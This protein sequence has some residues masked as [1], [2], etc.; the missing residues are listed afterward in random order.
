MQLF[1]YSDLKIGLL[2]LPEELSKHLGQVLRMTINQKILL[3]NGKGEYAEATISSIDKKRVF[4][5]VQ[6]ICVDKKVYFNIALGVAFTKNK[7]R[8]E[9][10][11]EK[12]TEIG[13]QHIYPII[14]SRTEGFVPKRDR[15][16]QILISAMCQSQQFIMPILH[17]AIPLSKMVDNNNFEELFIAHCLDNEPRQELINHCT[18]NKSSLILI[19]PEG[20]F[21]KDEISLCLQ[22]GF[23]PVSLGHNRLRTETAALVAITILNQIKQ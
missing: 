2:A 15:L 10:L 21:D 1:F 23:A 12:I 14:T 19:G 7:A 16:E 18:K 20:D 17:D 13:V 6:E 5:S 3:T 22:K 4:V 9:W 8:M 11:L